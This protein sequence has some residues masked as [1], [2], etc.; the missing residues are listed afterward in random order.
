M[1]HTHRNLTP[2]E[3]H[4][5]LVEIYW[6][7]VAPTFYNRVEQARK[8]NK[9]LCIITGHPHVGDPFVDFLEIEN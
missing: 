3:A 4:S 6:D 5:I 1:Y 9:T 8:A 7:E 2:D